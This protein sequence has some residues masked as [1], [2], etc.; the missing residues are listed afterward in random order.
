VAGAAVVWD[1]LAKGERRA[2]MR[3]Q[4]G[5]PIALSLT[6]AASYPAIAATSRAYVVGWTAQDGERSVVRTRVIR[7]AR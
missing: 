2:W 4:V 3:T 6:G 7:P 5:E 1:E